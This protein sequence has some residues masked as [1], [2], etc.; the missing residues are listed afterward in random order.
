MILRFILLCAALALTACGTTGAS[1]ENGKV[2]GMES[3]DAAYVMT[4]KSYHDTVHNLEKDRKPACEFKAAAGQTLKIE[5]L[6]SFACYGAGGGAQAAAMPAPAMPKTALAENLQAAGSFVKDVGSVAVPIVG[7]N[8][9]ADVLG[10]V[11]D[12]NTA[13]SAGAINLGAQG[14]NRRPDVFITN[15]SPEGAALIYPAA[16]Q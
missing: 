14:V 12:S 13:T 8:R 4:T 6:E 9:A 5:G 1:I 2:T 16:G 11:I 15:T 7:M 10:N 3:R